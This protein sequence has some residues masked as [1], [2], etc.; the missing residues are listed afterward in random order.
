M[1]FL[2]GRMNRLC[3]LLIFIFFAITEPAV[4]ADE[5]RIEFILG[6][7]DCGGNTVQAT[8]GDATLSASADGVNSDKI[9]WDSDPTISAPR[10]QGKKLAA[11]WREGG[12]WLIEFSGENLSNMTFSADM[13]SSGKAPKFFEMYYSINGTDFIKVDNSEVSLSKSNQTVYNDFALPKELNNK[14]K[15]YIKLMISSNKAV[16][17]SDITGVKDG[18]TYINNIIIKGSGGIKPDDGKKEEE[19]SYYSKRENIIMNRAGQP[20]GKYNFSV[21]LPQN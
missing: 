18:S 14:K 16:N 9:R 3:I 15:V 13:F 5:S 4:F 2:Y 12:Y 11:G 6:S 17:G 10:M 21:S 8:A 1:K 7:G 20:T 19:K